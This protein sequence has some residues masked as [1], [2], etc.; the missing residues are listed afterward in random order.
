M[1]ILIIDKC[2]GQCKYFGKVKH[3]TGCELS[4]KLFKD[5]HEYNKIPTWCRLTDAPLTSRQSRVADDCDCDDELSYND[6]CEDCRSK[7][8]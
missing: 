8:E 1:K 6:L 3:K 4:H 5:V 2:I 7:R